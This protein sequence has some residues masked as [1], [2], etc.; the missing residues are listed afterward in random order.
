MTSFIDSEIMLIWL[1]MVTFSVKEAIK[2]GMVQGFKKKKIVMTRILKQRL[3]SR[4]L[5][6]V[7][8]VLFI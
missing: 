5:I 1:I 7:V 8:D 2:R 4:I 3:H 6:P